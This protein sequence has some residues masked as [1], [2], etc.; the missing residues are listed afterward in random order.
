MPELTIPESYRPLV[1]VMFLVV[2][3][4][5]AWHGIRSRDAAGEA[6]P[7]RLLFG[8]IAALFFV[9]VLLRDVLG[10]IGF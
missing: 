5:V 6:D 9:V 10:V 7:V 3:G 1:D 4:A 2:T 8:S